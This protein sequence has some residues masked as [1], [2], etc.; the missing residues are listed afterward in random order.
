M[1]V[2]QIRAE[3][4]HYTSTGGRYHVFHAGKMLLESCRHPFYDGARA[5]LALGGCDLDDTLEQVND[6]GHPMLTGRLG[7]AAA[8]TISETQDHGPR[9][10]KWAPYDRKGRDDEE[11][12]D[13]L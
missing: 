5:L 8:H 13:D 4:S 9:L 11:N 12:S 3:L 7:F 6:L 10:V 1:A 2:H